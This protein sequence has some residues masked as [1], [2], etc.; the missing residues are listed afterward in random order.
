MEFN[1]T[2]DLE[3][4]KTWKILSEVFKAISNEIASRWF[5]VKI[6][7]VYASVFIN[8]SKNTVVHHTVW[9]IWTNQYSHDRE[10]AVK[11]EFAAQRC[12]RNAVLFIHSSLCISA[13]TQLHF[14]NTLNTLELFK[15]SD[16]L[17]LISN[18]K[19][20]WIDLC[21]CYFY[22]LRCW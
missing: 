10:T 6:K 4:V 18:R 1:G 2:N 15:P 7:P 3:K 14:V 8:V 11:T 9:W 17:I 21:K 20:R 16:R 19:L 22:F 13:L 5:G 12:F